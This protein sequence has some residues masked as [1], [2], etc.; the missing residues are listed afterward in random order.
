MNIRIA[1]LAALTLALGA[2]TAPA[3]AESQFATYATNGATDMVW[4]RIGVSGGSLHT[5]TGPTGSKA[6]ATNVSFSYEFPGL[7]ALTD[8]DAA[9]TLNATVAPGTPM[10]KTGST[11]IQ[12]GLSGTFSFIYTGTADLVVGGNTYSTGADLLSASFTGGSITGII[13]GKKG[14]VIDFG[15]IDYTSDLLSF[16]NAVDPQFNIDLVNRGGKFQYGAG[17]SMRSFRTGSDG[18]FSADPPELTPQTPVGVPEPATWAML[19][20]GFGGVGGALRTARRN[21]KAAIAA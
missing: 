12:S 4:Q 3:H 16:T 11:V 6:G 13:G 18:S 7:E 17:T 9:F 20:V 5:I 1:T 19:L 10:T 8:L 14:G 21:N 15:D 2:V